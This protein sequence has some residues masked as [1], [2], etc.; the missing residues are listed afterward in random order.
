VIAPEG[1]DFTFYPGGESQLPDPTE[2]AFEG[3][4]FVPAY[5]HLTRVFFR[6]LQLADYGNRIPLMTF[7]V[8]YN[9]SQITPFATMD[10]SGL[11]LTVPSGLENN[12]YM[13]IIPGTNEFHGLMEGNPWRANLSSMTA[14]Q[15]STVAAGT[16][17][18]AAGRDGF[19][20]LQN[21]ASN[22]EPLRKINATTGFEEETFG[23]TSTRTED[24]ADSFRNAGSWHHLQ[25]VDL[26]GTVNVL[27]HMM[28]LDS[29]TGSITN[30]DSPMSHIDL[31]PELASGGVLESIKGTA[32]PDHENNRFYTIT[33]IA[34]GDIEVGRIDFTL[35]LGAKTIQD[36][37]APVVATFEVTSLRKF[38]RGS[39]GNDFE[40]SGDPLGW[41]F[42]EDTGNIVISNA[43]GM[44]LYDPVAD[45][46][47]ASVNDTT[48]L[49]SS[50]NNYV[51]GNVF[52]HASG[53]EAVDGRVTVRDIRTLEITRVFSV[54]ILGLS[55]TPGIQ[56]DSGVWDSDSQALIYSR[57]TGPTVGERI[58]KVYIDRKSAVAIPLSDVTTSLLTS[59]NSLPLADLALT[60]FDDDNLASTL[61][62]GYSL[63]QQTS[64]ADAL[65]PLRLF[66]VHDWVEEDWILKSSLRGGAPV[67]TIPEEDVGKVR[68]NDKEEES[69]QE[70]RVQEQEMP[71][72]VAVRYTNVESDYDSDI[73]QSRRVINPTPT[74]FTGDET[75]L[76]IPV[77]MAS[78]KAKQLAQIWL[79]T[80][81]NERK[82]I[83]TEIPWKYLKLSPTD[84]VNV[85]MFGQTVTA[86]LGKQDVGTGYVTGIEGVTE[87]TSSFVSSLTGGSALGHLV[88]SVI[89]TKDPTKVIFLDSPLLKA[90]DLNVGSSSDAY[91]ALGG[92]GT[93]W[94]GGALHMSVDNV[95]FLNKG[96]SNN[97]MA[98]ATV[99][100][101]P[102]A[103]PNNRFQEIVEGGTMDIVPQARETV[104]VT[105]TELN[106]LNGANAFAV[107]TP[108]GIEIIQ[109]QT[110]TV[111]ADNTITLDRLLRGRFGTEAP[112]TAGSMTVADEIVFLEVPT[113]NKSNLS[114][115]DLNVTRFWKAITQGSFASS[116]VTKTFTYTGR[117]LSPYSPAQLV[118]SLDGTTKHGGI[119]VDWER[120]T[121]TNGEWKDGTGD[122]PLNE[123]LEEYNINFRKI[124]DSAITAT[125]TA[126]D[127]TR[128]DVPETTMV[129][130]LFENGDIL[131]NGNVETGDLTGWTVVSGTGWTADQIP[132]D[133]LT[134]PD[135]NFAAGNSWTI[136]F[137]DNTPPTD[138]V[139]EQEIDL[140]TVLSDFINLDKGLT[141]TQIWSSMGQAGATGGPSSRCPMQC[142]FKFIDGSDNTIETRADAFWHNPSTNVWKRVGLTAR[143]PTGTRKIAYQLVGS[144]ILPS[145]N[146]VDENEDP[147]PFGTQANGRSVFDNIHAYISDGIVT[148][149]VEVFQKSGSLI[150]GQV[151]T[152]PVGG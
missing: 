131:T 118:M 112:A 21:G 70:T 50:Q 26:L 23:I 73:E 138:W 150:D 113:V 61:I 57:G 91:F 65:E 7:L 53:G 109:F 99:Q 2:E 63:T 107:N 24:F 94:P 48:E 82:G 125:L 114:L 25:V 137:I 54:S 126:T 40:N 108:G 111:N 76:E 60:D 98:W 81:W 44:L 20:Y 56:V 64:V 105:D 119:E 103:W 120:R 149:N 145:T 1:F 12:D 151:A 58:V 6:D 140:S 121:R 37:P 122:V 3:V 29:A 28:D 22:S 59:Y 130:T 117:D 96:Q 43:G 33:S 45:A 135:P 15:E 9:T 79:Y 49:F 106:V 69:T 51:R 129:S 86:R 52:A 148:H 42:H 146:H 67:L 116:A 77:V 10:E 27:L 74:M 132:V 31:I 152:A 101:T 80:V 62:D 17:V 34:A 89:N 87:S 39:P 88:K 38:T 142:R 102:S 78:T 66:G 84:V 19:W 123:S 8:A 136:S 134:I 93:S 133:L 127:A 92:T 115:A 11:G 85:G 71:M 128:I 68:K 35:S 72:R 110:A 30:V 104:W 141:H 75:T 41:A 143:V 124:S 18:P 139:I 16:A 46:I 90:V 14:I 55:G 83:K 100:T 32:I 36:E 144:R 13:Q 97:E 95:N 5:R 147:A 47:L 4:G